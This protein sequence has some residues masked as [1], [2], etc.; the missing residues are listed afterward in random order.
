MVKTILGGVNK[1][2][3]GLSH[4]SPDRMSPIK[5]SLY[6]VYVRFFFAVSSILDKIKWNSKPPSPPNQGWSRAKGKNAPFFHPWFGGEGGGGLG[7]PFVLSKIAGRKFLCWFKII[8]LRSDW[9]LKETFNR[10]ERLGEFK[11]LLWQPEMA[12]LPSWHWF[13]SEANPALDQLVYLATH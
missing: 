12:S 11:L 6:G 2:E 1:V 10:S 5:P 7:F 9:Y 4:Y 13:K 3:R 8:S